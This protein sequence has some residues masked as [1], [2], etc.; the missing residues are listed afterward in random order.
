[1]AEQP[2]LCCAGWIA[3][4]KRRLVNEEGGLAVGSAAAK[5]SCG[6]ILDQRG[7]AW[8]G[9]LTAQNLGHRP[10]SGTCSPVGLLRRYVSTDADNRS[11]KARNLISGSTGL[12][13]IV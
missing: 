11:G 12:T 3:L 8:A 4:A 9:L 5:L 7:W 10:G 2:C 13:A 1:M 6:Q